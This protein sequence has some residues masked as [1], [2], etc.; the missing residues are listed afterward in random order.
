M[1][2]PENATSHHALLGSD[3]DVHCISFKNLVG[4]Y[5]AEKLFKKNTTLCDAISLSPGQPHLSWK[6]AKSRLEYLHSILVHRTC[7]CTKHALLDVFLVESHRTGNG[8]TDIDRCY[9]VKVHL[10]S[11]ETNHATYMRNHATCEQTRNNPSSKPATLNE[12]LINMVGV[13]IT[14]HSTKKRYIPLSERA[15]KCKYLPLLD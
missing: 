12:C 4:T 6:P 5:G 15:L 10:C 11:Q 2:S 1:G 9:V 13:I 7:N 14:S 3:I 8:V